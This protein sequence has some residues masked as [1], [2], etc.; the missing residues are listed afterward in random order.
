[1]NPK[2]RSDELIKDLAALFDRQPKALEF[3][4]TRHL[5]NV[6]Y[7]SNKESDI[8]LEEWLREKSRSVGLLFFSYRQKRGA[9]TDC[10]DEPC[11]F[12]SPAVPTGEENNFIEGE[13]EIR[14]WVSFVEELMKLHRSIGVTEGED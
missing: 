2:I 6:L 5:V 8:A 1:M 3:V 9:F 12:I 10:F 11:L 13:E 14:S 4:V 7:C